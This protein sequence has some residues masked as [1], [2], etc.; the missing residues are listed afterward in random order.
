MSFPSPAV[1]WSKGGRFGRVGTFPAPIE[2]P[3]IETIQ[4]PQGSHPKYQAP[5]HLWGE[6]QFSTAQSLRWNRGPDIQPEDVAGRGQLEYL[7]PSGEVGAGPPKASRTY[8]NPFTIS[9]DHSR[10]ED[11]RIRVTWLRTSRLG[12]RTG[13]E[14]RSRRV[15][16]PPERYLGRAR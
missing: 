7:G 12:Q 16:S 9:W 6:L 4:W 14:I 10:V 1:R 3:R 5:W 11:G 2:F 15:A 13:E 8:R